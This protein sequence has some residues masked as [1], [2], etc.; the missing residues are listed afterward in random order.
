MP[1][2]LPRRC[3]SII[4]YKSEEN[5]IVLIV[6]IPVLGRRSRFGLFF[7]NSGGLPF[8]AIFPVGL[9]GDQFGH[10]GG[11]AGLVAGAEAM[12]IVA[13]KIFV[14]QQQVF[15]PGFLVEV[16]V[17]PV[18]RAP[19]GFVLFKKTYHAIREFVGHSFQRK[20]LT[21]ACWV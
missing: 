16:I 8:M 9:F 4:P 5:E 1:G 7:Q 2:I 14:E 3:Q 15:V 13:V 21:G 18:C 11:P 10:E 20:L 12:T 19:A 6:R 17:F